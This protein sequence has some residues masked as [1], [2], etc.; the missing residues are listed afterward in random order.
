MHAL[1]KVHF[2]CSLYLYPHLRSQ[3]NGNSLV[4]F[5]LLFDFDKTHEITFLEPH[6]NA[7]TNEN[8][9]RA[10]ESNEKRSWSCIG[11]SIFHY[12]ET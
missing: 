4:A 9:V 2:P 11:A 7:E 5:K 1:L 10:R 6:E 3:Q 12:F 8:S